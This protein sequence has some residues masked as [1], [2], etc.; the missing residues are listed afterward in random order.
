MTIA[1]YPATFDPIHNGHIDIAVRAAR[2]FD[3]VI[4]AAYAR[5]SKNLMFSVEERVDLWKSAIHHLPNVTV[6]PYTTLTVDFVTQIGA[7]VIVRGLRMSSDFEGEFEMA[8]MNKQISPRVESVFLM[9]NLPFQFLSSSL[10][11]EVVQLGGN[12]ASLVPPNVL[13]ALNT[14]F[15]IPQTK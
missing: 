10:L 5:P 7:Q 3:V 15:K 2:I 1:V 4:A 13:K 14:K 9:A 11:K 8:L 6:T 12:V